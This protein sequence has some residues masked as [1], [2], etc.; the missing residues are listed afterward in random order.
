MRLEATWLEATREDVEEKDLVQEV[1]QL[2][3]WKVT[4]CMVLDA[5]STSLLSWW[6]QS[7]SCFVGKVH[8]LKGNGVL[9]CI[10]NT[11]VPKAR[12]DVCL[13]E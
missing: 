12:V 3:S 10:Q 7:G 6:E 13:I 2:G 4:G 11:A 8:E 1:T 5:G 9:L